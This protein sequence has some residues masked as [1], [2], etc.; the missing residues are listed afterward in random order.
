MSVR[1]KKVSLFVGPL[2]F[3]VPHTFTLI[4]HYAHTM[5]QFTAQQKKH[6]ILLH[7]Q[8]R[9]DDQTPDHI[10]RLHGVSGGRRTL[11]KWREKWDG[12]AAS[13]ERTA[14]SGRP[15]LLTSTQVKQLI[16]TPIVKKNRAHTAISYT[17]LLPSILQKTHSQITLR[18]VQRYGKRDAGIKMK[19][20]KKGTVNES[21]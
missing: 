11:N 12:S 2:S 17:Q 15:R 10:A 1:K 9:R 8:S 21:E 14:V 18:T 19:H 5:K 13:L 6:S 7:L 4:R 3:S 16:H 20:T